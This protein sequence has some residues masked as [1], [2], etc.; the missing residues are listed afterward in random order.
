MIYIITGPPAAGKTTYVHTHAKP[1]DIRIDLDH[2]ANL[3]TGQPTANH[4]HTGDALTIARAARNAAITQALNHHSSDVYIIHTKPNQQQLDRYTKA[5]AQ[6]I[7]ID[8][9]K[10]T[11]LERCTHQRPAQSYHA[12]LQWYQAP[13]SKQTTTQ[14]GYGHQHRKI[15]KA[16]IAKHVDGSPCPWCGQPMYKNPDLN[17]DR[18]PLAA[19]HLEAG[20]AK[21]G[22]PARRL[23]HYVCNSQRKDGSKPPPPTTPEPNTNGH[24]YR[25]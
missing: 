11:V 12:A 20:G 1:G 3:I 22:L 7:T 15:R 10:H 6:I 17:P 23:L 21:Q 9:G 25:W 14:R 19:D 13:K 8:P 2:L 16:L 24:S 18:K 5:G 4:Q